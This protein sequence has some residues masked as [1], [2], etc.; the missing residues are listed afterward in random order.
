MLE[1]YTIVKNAA[2][3]YLL[4]IVLLYYLKPEIFDD[5]YEKKKAYIIAFFVSFFSF[6]FTLYQYV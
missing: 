5:P 3:V 4:I 6:Y 2:L 1:D